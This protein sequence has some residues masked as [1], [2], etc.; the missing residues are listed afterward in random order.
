MGRELDRG[1]QFGGGKPALFPGKQALLRRLNIGGRII[2]RRSAGN[3][4]LRVQYKNFFQREGE[5][6]KR[7]S[8]KKTTSIKGIISIRAFRETDTWK[9]ER[10]MRR[11]V[12]LYN[13]PEKK[14]LPGVELG[15]R[16]SFV[17]SCRD[18][19]ETPV[20]RPS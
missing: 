14:I 12:S 18:P 6:D 1:N 2:V 3:R 10:S 19:V 11:G 16:E 8:R 5:K 17:P 9:G 7:A 4:Y 20:S 15:S 13:G